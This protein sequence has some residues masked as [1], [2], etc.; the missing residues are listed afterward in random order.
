M[1]IEKGLTGHQLYAPT[2]DTEFFRDSMIYGAPRYI[3]IDKEGK[4]IDNN[5]TGWIN[6]SY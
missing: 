5:A 1:V 2:R 6:F 4:I 3:L